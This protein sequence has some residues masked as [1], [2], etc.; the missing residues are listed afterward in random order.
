MTIIDTHLH[1]K[2]TAGN[3]AVVNKV[4]NP[5]GNRN[6][7]KTSKEVDKAVRDSSVWESAT[8]KRRGGR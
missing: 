2:A 3:M 4:F 1:A 5:G 8:Q 7:A 6:K